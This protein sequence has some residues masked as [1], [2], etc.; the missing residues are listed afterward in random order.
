M[1][2]NFGILHFN[3][4]KMSNTRT[5]FVSCFG[6]LDREWADVLMFINNKVNLMKL[7]LK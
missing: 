7:L 2:Y 3:G 6:Q 4:Q 5:F 1:T